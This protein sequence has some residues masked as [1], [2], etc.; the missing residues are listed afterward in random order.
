MKVSYFRIPVILSIVLISCGKNQYQTNPQISIESITGVVPVGGEL[1]AKFKFTQKNSNLSQGVF[2]AIRQRLN[3][4]PLPPGT[5]IA[6][7]TTFPIPNYPD[8]NQGEFELVLPYT[9]LNESNTEND[10]IM[11]KFVA[12]DREGRVSDTIFTGNIVILYQ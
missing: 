3:V 8:K 7:T 5:A 10:T 12:A 2:T 6:D 11:F 9:Y 4:Q 1:D